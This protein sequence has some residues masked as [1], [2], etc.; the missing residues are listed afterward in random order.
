V[1]LPERSFGQHEF[2]DFPSCGD[3]AGK[4]CQN[5]TSQM[6]VPWFGAEEH[7]LAPMSALQGQALSGAKWSDGPPDP[8]LVHPDVRRMLLTMRAVIEGE[9]VLALRP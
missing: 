9:R 7:H 6:V 5:L 8:I 2:L 4:L 1:R 3:Q